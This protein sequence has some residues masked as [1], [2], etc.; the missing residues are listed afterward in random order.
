MGKTIGHLTLVQFVHHIKDIMDEIYLSI[1]NI[2]RGAT[3]IIVH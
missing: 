3:K 2:M 1:S